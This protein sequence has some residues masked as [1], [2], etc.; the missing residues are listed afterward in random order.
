MTP[1]RQQIEAGQRLIIFALVAAI[2]IICISAGAHRAR[3]AELDLVTVQTE[4]GPITVA[5]SFARKIVPLIAAFKAAGLKARVKC[6]A[7]KRGHHVKRSRHLTGNACDFLPPRPGHRV[8]RR[9]RRNR[10]PTPA[11]MFTGDAAALIAS[12]GLRNG[13]SFRDCGHVDSGLQPH[14]TLEA[15]ARQ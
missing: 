2:I 14:R 4:L 10:M 12:A 13:C 15:R 7:A 5:R 6:F 9:R 1:F 11:F 8:A 3:G